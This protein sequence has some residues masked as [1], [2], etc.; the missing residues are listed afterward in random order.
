MGRHRFDNVQRYVHPTMSS[1]GLLWCH[2]PLESPSYI[3]CLLLLCAGQPNCP[4][5]V[6]FTLKPIIGELWLC[7]IPQ[8]MQTQTFLPDKVKTKHSFL[9]QIPHHKHGSSSWT[10]CQITEPPILTTPSSP[11]WIS[12]QI[13]FWK[14]P[15]CHSHSAHSLCFPLTWFIS[16]FLSLTR[17][18]VRASHPLTYL[19]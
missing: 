6:Q 10:F 13:L 16:S 19:L 2:T 14:P 4:V 8:F 5:N 12:H 9:H 15:K 3:L 11:W 17:I 18:T 7:H 1:P